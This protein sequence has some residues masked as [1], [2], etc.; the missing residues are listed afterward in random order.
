MFHTEQEERKERSKTQDVSHLRFP[1]SPQVDPINRSGRFFIQR[2]PPVKFDSQTSRSSSEVKMNA[3]IVVG[4]DMG[5]YG[6]GIHSGLVALAH[7]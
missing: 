7:C 2:F 6:T 3:P 1:S 4:I 5:T